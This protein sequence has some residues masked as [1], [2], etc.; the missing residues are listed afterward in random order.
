[1]MPVTTTTE[2]ED[3]CAAPTAAVKM[4]DIIPHVV[5]DTACDV[6]HPL[7]TGGAANLTEL[8][9]TKRRLD[10]YRDVHISEQHMLE[11]L[12]IYATDEPLQKKRHTITDETDDEGE[13]PNI[14]TRHS[15]IWGKVPPK[16]PKRL[17]KCTICDRDVSALRFAPHL[18][19]CMNLGTV[20][21]AAA[22]NTAVSSARGTAK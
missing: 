16:E 11:S 8:Q 17:A 9:A 19:K 4:D 6:T 21:A 3:A 15:D 5:T 10:L 22:N 20:R 18:D 7:Q 12:K 13:V 1:M 2:V 14:V